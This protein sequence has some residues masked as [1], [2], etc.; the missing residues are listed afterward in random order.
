MTLKLQLFVLI[1]SLELFLK[2][3]HVFLAIRCAFHVVLM[4]QIVSCVGQE[5][6]LSEEN[7]FHAPKIVLCAQM[8]QLA[9]SVREDQS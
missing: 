7:V 6:I 3:I 1:A 2:M 8:L 9:P 4:L 5:N